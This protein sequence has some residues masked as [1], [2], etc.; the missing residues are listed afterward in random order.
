VEGKFSTSEK[1]KGDRQSPL[2]DLS[3]NLRL[4]PFAA[5]DKT[6]SPTKH[7]RQRRRGLQKTKGRTEGSP[8]TTPPPTVQGAGKDTRKGYPYDKHP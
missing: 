3:D 5:G 7:R 1:V 6:L 2:R 4:S 8:L